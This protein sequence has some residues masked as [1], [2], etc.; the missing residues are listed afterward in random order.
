MLSQTLDPTAT[1]P[2]EQLGIAS[3]VCATW[4]LVA[5]TLWRQTQRQQ[6]TINTLRE[7]QIKREREMGDRIVPL[8]QSAADMLSRAPE[9]FDRALGQAQAASRSSEVD[10][11][12]SYLKTS[13]EQIVKDRKP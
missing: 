13:V 8:L 10:Q 4:F 6:A 1:N 7:E 5:Y 12:L 9:R 3:I 2:W 11:L